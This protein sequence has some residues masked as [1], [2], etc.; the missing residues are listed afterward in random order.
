MT[1]TIALITPAPGEL[2]LEQDELGDGEGGADGWQDVG[3][4]GIVWRAAQVEEGDAFEALRQELE[5]VDVEAVRFVADA[6]VHVG[7]DVGGQGQLVS[8]F[9]NFFLSSLLFEGKA[10]AN[11]M[12]TFYGRSLQIFLIG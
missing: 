7:E 5:D 6:E 9:L 1:K 10:R 4:A 2:D 11:V 12:K 8:M 3:T